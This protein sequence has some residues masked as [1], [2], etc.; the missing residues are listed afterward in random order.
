MTGRVDAR[1]INVA[2]R[3]PGRAATSNGARILRT[4]DPEQ[5]DR[6]ERPG[7]VPVSAVIPGQVKP[8]LP[9]VVVVSLLVGIIAFLAG[10]QLGRADT[11]EV[12]PSTPSPS[13]SPLSASPTPVFE[14]SDFAISFEPQRLMLG[15]AD[16][17]GCVTHVAGAPGRDGPQTDRTL[18]RVWL[19]SC[20]IE[21][22]K[23][24]P[25]LDGLF[26]AMEEQIPNST[27]SSS[28]DPEGMSI[29]DF[30]YAQGSSV[31]T[32][33]LAADAYGSGLVI[34]ITIQERLLQ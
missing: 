7:V 15:L 5:E 31:G 9:R 19:T 29:A 12:A 8:T 10:L 23:R 2:R 24:G 34:A 11:A 27:N 22:K 26:S 3:E 30:A 32:V 13:A 17:A 16:G 33:T 28:S 6:D 1:T 4:N 14:P 21:A 20:P 18:V 25:F